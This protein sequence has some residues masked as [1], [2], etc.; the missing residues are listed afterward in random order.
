MKIIQI[1]TTGVANVSNTQCDWVMHALTDDG[2]IFETSNVHGWREMAL[3]Q[4]QQPAQET[5]APP[6]SCKCPAPPGRD[7][8]LTVSECNARAAANRGV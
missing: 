3:P 7:C 6:V 5:G 1:T 4:E 2:R 8:W